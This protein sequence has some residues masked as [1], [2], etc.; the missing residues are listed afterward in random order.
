MYKPKTMF[1]DKVNYDNFDIA[2]NP[3]VLE[4]AMQF[5]YN[6]KVRFYL[7]EKETKQ[8]SKEHIWLTPDGDLVPLKLK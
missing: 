1:Y 3:T 4:P 8:P 2:I 6:L 5:M 7:Q